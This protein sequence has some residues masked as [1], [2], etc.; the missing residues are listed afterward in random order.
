MST[1]I[2]HNDDGTPATWHEVERGNDDM[3]EYSVHRMLFPHVQALEEDQSDIHLQNVLNAKLFTNRELM[4]FEWNSQIIASFRPLTANL[5]NL[6]QSAVDTM[7]SRLA[8]SRPRPKIQTRG[9]SFDI[10]RKGRQLDR[11]AWGEF[12]GQKIYEKAERAWIEDPMLYGTGFMKIDIDE[13]QKCIFSERTHPDEI[14]VDQRECVSND[15]PQ[16]LYQRKLVSRLWLLKKFGARS[17]KVRQAIL[18]AQTKSWRYTS[19]RS[20]VEDQ[21]VLIQGW[22]LETFPGAGDGREVLCIE[23]CTLFDRPYTRTRF[24]FVWVKWRDPQN[25]FYGYPLVSDIMGYQINQNEMNDLLKAGRDL[26]C[27]PRIFI[28]QGSDVQIHHIDNQ[29]AKFIR[30]RGTMPECITWPA[31]NPEMYNER[32]RNPSRMYDMIGLSESMATASAPTSQTRFDSSDAL[33]EYDGQ[34]DRRLIRHA[35]KLEAAYLEAADH[36]IELAAILY[37]KHSTSRKVVYHNGC[38]VVDE[39]DWPSVDMKRDQYVM[40]IAAS[41]VLSMSPAARTDKLEGWLRD[42]K[43]T[44]EQYYSLSGEPDFERLTDRLAAQQDHIEAGIDRL[45]KGKEW[46]PTPFDNLELVFNLVH[47]ELLRLMSLED[48]PPAVIDSFVQTL[49]LAKEIM[50]PTPDPMSQPMADP[51]MNLAAGP[52]GPPP[53]M[54]GTGGSPPMAPPG[55]PPVVPAA[56]GGPVPAPGPGFPGAV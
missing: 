5:E 49:E 50:S 10:Y 45:L 26:A 17:P 44:M 14:I 34:Q 37:S 42:Q 56:P 16:T 43:I 3:D 7:F 13:G 24:P 20:P 48:T 25:G 11:Y 52:M 33:K 29:V 30:Y 23:N 8:T 54:P 28:E 19:Y 9:A 55:V 6:V 27:V 53:T 31:F 32:D 41:S 46:T 38:S 47:D 4:A 40:T 35:M 1:K 21:I 22:K 51:A 2:L 15:M 12:Q 36:F 18:E 39:I